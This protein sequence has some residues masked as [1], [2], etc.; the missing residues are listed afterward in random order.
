MITLV[1]IARRMEDNTAFAAVPDCAEILAMNVQY[2][3]MIGYRP[4]WIGYFAEDNGIFKGSGGFKGAPFKGRVE[5]AYS[6]FAQ[7][8]HQGIGTAICRKLVELARAADPTVIIAART[9]PDN[10]YSTRILRKNGFVLKGMVYDKDDGD[11][12][13]W[14]YVPPT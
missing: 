10:N 5:I 1:P 4:P 12:W 13:E 9:L 7:F 14:H 8:R 11:V 3:D 2:Y 6:T